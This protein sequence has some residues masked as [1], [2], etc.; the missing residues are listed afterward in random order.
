MKAQQA[1]VVEHH[2]T[3]SKHCAGPGCNN[4]TS[5]PY[6]KDTGDN[7]FCKRDC[8]EKYRNEQKPRFPV[9]MVD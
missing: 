8:W 2:P 6:A 9:G 5:Y 7:Y 3:T 4:T 1:K